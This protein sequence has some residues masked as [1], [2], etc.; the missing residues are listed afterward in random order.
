MVQAEQLKTLLAVLLPCLCDLVA[1]AAAAQQAAVG[2]LG[3]WCA[4]VVLQQQLWAMCGS[5]QGAATQGLHL[6]C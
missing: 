3:A 1:V 2:Q 4:A 6:C 5:K